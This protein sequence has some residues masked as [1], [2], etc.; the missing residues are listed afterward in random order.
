M[1][2]RLIVAHYRHEVLRQAYKIV[3]SIDLLGNPIGILQVRLRPFARLSF[4]SSRG[5]FFFCFVGMP[6]SLVSHAVGDMSAIGGE[7]WCQGS[8]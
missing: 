1:L 6:T 5:A 3:G 8:H 4:F 7:L 2:T